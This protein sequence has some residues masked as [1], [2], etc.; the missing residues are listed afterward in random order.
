MVNEGPKV[1]AA[2]RPEEKIV[3]DCT[4]QPTPPGTGNPMTFMV[5]QIGNFVSNVLPSGTSTSNPK[6]PTGTNLPAG[7]SSSETWQFSIDGSTVTATCSSSGLCSL[8]V[9]SMSQSF[10]VPIEQGYSATGTV[11]MSGSLNAQFAGDRISMSG[12]ES[13]TVSL[14]AG[15]IPVTDPDG[16]QTTIG[17]PAVNE[18]LSVACS[19]SGTANAAY[20]NAT[21]A[22][23]TFSESNPTIGTKSF[24]WTAKWTGA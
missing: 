12:S 24:P 5:A 7:G 16:Q 19:G 23:G 22:S 18:T 2:P 14:P 1:L 10:S 8:P 20:P 21:T 13:A 9:P 4:A 17:Y 6:T 11:S 3:L 15:S